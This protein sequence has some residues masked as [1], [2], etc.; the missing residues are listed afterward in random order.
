[1]VVK[2]QTLSFY[3]WSTFP[4][5]V[6]PSRAISGRCGWTDDYDRSLLHLEPSSRD[7][8][9]KTHIVDLTNWLKFLGQRVFVSKLNRREGEYRR[10]PLLNFNLFSIL[11]FEKSLISIQFCDSVIFG[12]YEIRRLRIYL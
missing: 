12:R 10:R 8:I 2:Y 11:Q 1:M 4:F 5:S 9:T 6:A 7:V 3:L